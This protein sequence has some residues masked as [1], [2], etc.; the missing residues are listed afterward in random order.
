MIEVEAGLVGYDEREV[1]GCHGEYVA[2]GP[3]FEEI[4]SDVGVELEKSLKR[5][6]PLL[7]FLVRR[8]RPVGLAF[9][10]RLSPAIEKVFHCV[11]GAP[12]SIVG[13]VDCIIKKEM[14]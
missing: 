10:A 8:V 14:W 4:K 3:S 13:Y 5:Y 11:H 9:E 12:D 2:E 7:E 6:Q 1:G